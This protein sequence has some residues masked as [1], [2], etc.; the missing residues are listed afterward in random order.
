MACF[1]VLRARRESQEVMAKMDQWEKRFDHVS[2]IFS[3]E[4]LPTIVLSDLFREWAGFF[5]LG[6]IDL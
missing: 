1:V 5:S 3:Q 4:R 6:R 2:Y